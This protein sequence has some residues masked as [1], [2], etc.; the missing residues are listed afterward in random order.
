M[1][2]NISDTLLL[3]IKNRYIRTVLL[4]KDKRRQGKLVKY[5]QIKVKMDKEKVVKDQIKIKFG[6]LKNKIIRHVDN[7]IKPK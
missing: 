2:R 1:K 6:F 5:Y 7:L 3:K 4:C